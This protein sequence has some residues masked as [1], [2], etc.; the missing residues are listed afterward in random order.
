MGRTIM[1]DD[2]TTAL[3][4]PVVMLS[5]RYWQSRFAG[6]PSI[7]NKTMVV[8]GH[9]FTVIGVAAR[10]FDGIEP[11]SVTEVFVPV[12]MKGWIT[13]TARAWKSSRTAAAPG[14]RFSGG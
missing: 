3:G 8:N 12:T 14:S 1:P 5:H 11:G 9:N 10:G 7:L 2:D 4:H 13:P 6:D